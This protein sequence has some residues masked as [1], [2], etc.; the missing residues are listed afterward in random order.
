M[1]NYRL[2]VAV[3]LFTFGLLTIVQVILSSPPLLLLERFIRGGGWFEIVAV[4]LYGAFIAFKMQDPA[5]I[6]RLRKITWII[7]SAVF[8]LQ[9][10]TGLLGADKFLMTGKL[11]LPIPVMILSGP[12]YRGHLS[13]MTILF[14]S[15][16]ILTGPAWCSHLCYFG[17][18]DN[19]ASGTTAR[20]EVLKNK[21]AIKTIL[22]ILVIT[23]T[24]ILRWLE[25]P[26]MTATIAAT[27]FG[28][29]GI[30]IMAFISRKKGK[31][32]HCILYCPIG[33]L[34]NLIR[35]INPFR[36]YIDKNCTFC[37]KCTSI[38]KYDALNV[39][40]IRNRKPGFSCTFC[41]DCLAGCRE[42]SIK[43]HFLKMQPQ[44]ARKIYLF[45]TISL[46]ASFLALARI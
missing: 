24:L 31:M 10:I 13:V 15:T 43:Y 39:Q 14:L 36:I 2:P 17:A 32:V 8:F 26:V 12:L 5:N 28:L 25:V 33:T 35:Y 29:T 42:N 4:A 22:L 3:F 45:L 37:M 6:S 23:V 1:E 9:L 20:K 41:G 27:G 46:H 11:H 7:F 38:C 34:V 18:F 19:L 40:D 30:L 44:S 21:T 16:I